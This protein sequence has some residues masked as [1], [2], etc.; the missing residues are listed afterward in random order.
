MNKVSQAA[1]DEGVGGR[2]LVKVEQGTEE[3]KR[4]K[5]FCFSL[6]GLQP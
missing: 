5:N 4:R 3:T 6:A 1:V 2:T